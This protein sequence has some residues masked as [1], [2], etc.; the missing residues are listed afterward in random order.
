M[1][2]QAGFYFEP[3]VLADVND[4]M[5]CQKGEIFGPILPLRSFSGVEEAL[6]LANQ[7]TTEPR[8]MNEN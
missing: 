4:D 1:T 2:S 3:T 6:Q 7:V 8:T 5:E